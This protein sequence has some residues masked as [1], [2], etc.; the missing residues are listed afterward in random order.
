MGDCIGRTCCM[1]TSSEL[2][3]GGGGGVGVFCTMG[4][5]VAMMSPKP[6]RSWGWSQHDAMRDLKVGSMSSGKGSWALP[7]P[8]APTTCS[9]QYT[10]LCMLPC[11]HSIFAPMVLCQCWG[12][13]PGHNIV[14]SMLCTAKRPICMQLQQS[15]I[16]HLYVVAPDTLGSALMHTQQHAAMQRD[17][18]S[19]A[20]CARLACMAFL[21]CQGSW[22]VHSSH[23]MTPKE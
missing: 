18:R 10:L 4:F 20:C 17:M 13:E 12:P 1:L 23:R 21:S 15:T 14:K 9:I 7:Q 3:M 22:P 19:Q 6:G 5:R 8:T 16:K 2:S 11:D